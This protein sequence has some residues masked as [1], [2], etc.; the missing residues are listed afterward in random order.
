MSDMTV[1]TGFTYNKNGFILPVPSASEGF[2]LTG[3]G[4]TSNIQSI[5]TGAHEALVL[6]EVSTAG[7][8]YLDNLD[9]TNYVEIGLDV[10]AAFAPLLKL[11]AGQRAMLWL[12]TTAVY[13]KANTG[14]VKLAYVITDA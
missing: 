5:G 8:L 4:C 14:A 1:T 10:A 9:A 12:T 2:S 3:A 6:G 13:A 7:F 11:K